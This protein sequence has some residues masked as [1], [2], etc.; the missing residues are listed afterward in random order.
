METI[1]LREPVFFISYLLIFI[2]SVLLLSPKFRDRVKSNFYKNLLIGISVVMTVQIIIVCKHFELHYLLPAQLLTVLGLIAA[3]S[4]AVE[5]FPKLIKANKL[6]YISSILIL[7]SSIQIYFFQKNITAV[8]Q[9]RE[10]SKEFVGKVEK[11]FR[12]ETIITSYGVSSREMALIIGATYGG[13]QRNNYLSLLK[14]KFPDISYYDKW[15]KV[16]LNS[17]TDDSNKVRFREKDK[18]IF[19]TDNEVVVTDLIQY[20]KEDPNLQNITLKK[21]F[22]NSNG[23]S[24]FEIYMGN[25]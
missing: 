14:N 24:I 17:E 5:I 8:N 16:L 25:H 9:K 19:L 20:L 18:I 7:F 6:V 2:T 11:D 13:S 3:G 23:E 15:S 12:G 4:I 10:V 1:F 21:L 22:S